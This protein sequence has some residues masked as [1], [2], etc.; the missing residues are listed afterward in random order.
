MSDSLLPSLSTWIAAS[1]T[2]TPYDEMVRTAGEVAAGCE[3]DLVYCSQ[4]GRKFFGWWMSGA[5]LKTQMTGM[6]IVEYFYCFNV[7]PK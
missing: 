2:Q 6:C 3:R 1:G 4:L 7:C 5:L